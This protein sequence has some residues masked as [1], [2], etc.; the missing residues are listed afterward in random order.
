MQ[1]KALTARDIEQPVLNRLQPSCAYGAIFLRAAAH[2]IADCSEGKLTYS[3]LVKAIDGFTEVLMIPLFVHGVLETYLM[4]A[5]PEPLNAVLDEMDGLLENG[6]YLPPATQPEFFMSHAIDSILAIPGLYDGIDQAALEERVREQMDDTIHILKQLTV[7]KPPGTASAILIA[8]AEDLRDGTAPRDL[9]ELVRNANRLLPM[10]AVLDAA[11]SVTYSAVASWWRRV[12]AQSEPR[13]VQQLPKDW[14]SKPHA[15]TAL[16]AASKVPAPATPPTAPLARYSDG[17][18]FRPQTSARHSDGAACRLLGALRDMRP[19]R[20]S[21]EA[22]PPI[23]QLSVTG[24]PRSSLSG[25][26]AP[27]C[28]AGVPLRPPRSSYGGGIVPH[29]RPAAD[30]AALAGGMRALAL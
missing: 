9:A 6:A 23:V 14:T 15:S 17:A 5:N 10:E 24:T 3:A 1:S 16:S 30:V 26:V 11:E 4:D 28:T 7:D 18:Y 21:L 13:N 29:A 20:A 22:Q 25:T 27:R 19:A 12:W 2:L 8:Y